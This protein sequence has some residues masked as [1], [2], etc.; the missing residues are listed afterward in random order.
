MSTPRKKSTIPHPFDDERLAGDLSDLLDDERFDSYAQE[1]EDAIL[2]ESTE[3]LSSVTGDDPPPG[4]VE[5]EQLRH[6][7]R[8]ILRR[9]AL[10]L[11]YLCQLDR[12]EA[13]VFQIYTAAF[14]SE[15]LRPAA[16]PWS[17]L[18]HAERMTAHFLSTRGGIR[19]VPRA[20]T[21]YTLF[22]GEP[23][24]V[25]MFAMRLSRLRAKGIVDRTA[26]GWNVSAEFA[27]IA[28]VRPVERLIPRT[29]KM[30]AGLEVIP[31][32]KEIEEWGKELRAPRE[33]GRVRRAGGAR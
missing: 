22:S 8:D 24:T 11:A 26:S 18:A 31:T 29:P 20:V 16:V 1:L 10:H 27:D 32:W 25:S 7:Y 6:L 13:R 21:G 23:V 5:R 33:D 17:S 30:R 3:D 4:D 19:K 9:R 2:S 15:S 14:P 28:Q 12:D